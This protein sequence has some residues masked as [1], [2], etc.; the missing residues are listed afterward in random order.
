LSDQGQRVSKRYDAVASYELI[1]RIQMLAEQE[2]FPVSPIKKAQPVTQPTLETA[3]ITAETQRPSDVSYIA[4]AVGVGTDGKVTGCTLHSAT[5][6]D[7]LDQHICDSLKKN[8]VIRPAVNL[9]TN[10]PVEDSITVS[11]YWN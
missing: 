3:G 1:T 5:E 6:N 11:L 9:R 8:L 7:A 4:A 2:P 10:E